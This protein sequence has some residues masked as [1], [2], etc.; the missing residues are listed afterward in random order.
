M[1][2]NATVQ[3]ALDLWLELTGKVQDLGDE[4][5]VQ[6][7]H[8]GLYDANEDLKDSAKLDP[9]GLLTLLL[10][11]FY[12][13]EYLTQWRL[14]AIL[15]LG[16]DYVSPHLKQDLAE[17]RGD[18]TLAKRL[19]DLL[20]S[21]ELN[22]VRDEFR[23]G[24]LVTLHSCGIDREDV[25]DLLDEK[26]S[27]AFLRRDALRAIQ[28]L[29]VHQFMQGDSD[30][31]L[32]VFHPYLMRFWNINSMIRAFCNPST[33]SG[34]ALCIMWEP[35]AQ[36]SYF[37]FGIKN[38]GTFS[39]LTDKTEDAH[40]LAKSM[41]RSR[42]QGRRF[43]E[44]KSKYHFPYQVLGIQVNDSGDMT[45]NKTH[46]T[47]L[48]LYQERPD[49]ITRIA[50]LDP[51][52]LIW[53]T[54]VFGL[55]QQ[56]FWVEN[57]RTPLLSYTGEMVRVPEALGAGR[58]LMKLTDYKPL[59]LPPI[60]LE[61][62]TNPAQVPDLGGW[63][64][65]TR[66]NDWMVDRYKDLVPEA[67]L[68]RIGPDEVAFLPLPPDLQKTVVAAQE[69]Q[70]K[71]LELWSTP[72]QL[73]EPYKLQSLDP[74]RFGTAAEIE[75]DRYWTARYNLAKRVNRAAREEYLARKDEVKAWYVGRV[76]ANAPVL[77]R[78][79]AVG[80]LVAPSIV[81]DP[82]AGFGSQIA[83][84]N[85]MGMWERA[86]RD[87]AR[88]TFIFG[89]SKARGNSPVAVTLCHEYRER[90]P[91]GNWLTRSACFVTRTGGNAPFAAYFLPQTAQA[92]A[93]VC[94][95]TVSDLP[96]VL[97]HW[98]SQSVKY[99]G[100]SILSR[101]DPMDWVAKDPWQDMGFGVRIMLSRS[102]YNQIR[103]E[104]GLPPNRFWGSDDQE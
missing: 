9:S 53:I 28:R 77:L 45:L 90:T 59:E 29:T 93:I 54:M 69:R 76:Q 23:A 99:K 101:V 13:E 95:C 70:E 82:A 37:A 49:P 3:K 78:A 39:V 57:Y 40:P 12:L 24:M 88:D 18:I 66:E 30:G 16:P 11:D 100:N 97:Q 83:D 80:E 98:T 42:A 17:I 22:A 31:A 81:H 92:L 33:P 65:G 34:V 7:K 50:D 68:N 79:V 52:Q 87:R 55:I 103:R 38:G 85:I 5:G 32:P 62:V 26:H 4:K 10:L 36:H 94:G 2:L 47:G 60:T 21:E 25:L 74:T 75:K 86:K 14:P 63:R 41:S 27:L 64:P 84:A 96:D 61:A 56:R 58:S 67:D 89:S 19:F 35:E 46:R 15:M 20:R 6:I 8:W 1:N 51:V 43:D 72:E 102:G 44:R 48:V 71:G 104:A 91:S 73:L